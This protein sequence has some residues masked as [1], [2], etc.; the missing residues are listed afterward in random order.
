MSPKNKP[1]QIKLAIG[2]AEVTKYGKIFLLGAKPPLNEHFINQVT[3][4]GIIQIIAPT[5]YEDGSQTLAFRRNSFGVKPKDKDRDLAFAYHIKQIAKKSGR[6]SLNGTEVSKVK[7]IKRS[8]FDNNAK[9]IK[10]KHI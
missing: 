2:K 1:E 3:Q 6:L 4:D 8:M 5:N 10:K 7:S 9:S